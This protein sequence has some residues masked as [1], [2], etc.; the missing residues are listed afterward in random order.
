MQR[1]FFLSSF[2]LKPVHHR[3]QNATAHLFAYF[4]ALMIVGSF[5]MQL[6]FL[7]TSGHAVPYLDGLFTTVS[8]MC[9]TGLST[10][11]MSVYTDT[12]FITILLIIEAG[13]LGLVTLFTVYL[14]F[15]AKHISLE[16]RSLI[17]NYFTSDITVKPRDI[18]FRIIAVTFIIQTIGAIVLA[19]FLKQAGENRFIFYGIFLSISAFCNAGFTPYSDSLQRFTANPA[20]Y[21]TISALIITGGLGFTVISDCASHIHRRLHHQKSGPL[22]LHTEIVLVM[23]ALLIVL[24]TALIFFFDRTNAFNNMTFAQTLGNAFFQSVTVRTAGFDTVAQSSFSAE[25]TLASILLMLVGGSPGSLAGGLKTTTL[26]LL[27]C[28]TF[29]S[30][31]DRNHISVF[32]RD[33]SW[34]S[35]EK[36]VGI[37][38]KGFSIFVIVLFLLLAAEG[39]AL[40]AGAFSV[41][42]IV[43]EI[44]SAFGTVGLSKGVTPLLSAAGK[45][46]IIATMFAGRTGV[47]ALAMQ[48]PTI[49]RKQNEVSEYPQEDILVG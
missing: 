28:Y 47:F 19:L 5:V 46:I 33:I 2:V 6:P 37:M 13:G 20:I 35:L 4:F 21:L 7:Y 9:V 25:S 36:A 39:H 15:P 22:T 12:G 38:M 44:A 23:T 49:H 1:R 17:C 24:G 16:N 43:F 42:D 14:A 10:V 18:L 29:R 8:A 40:A 48:M 3:L 41:G 26:F 27:W 32:R 30:K 34:P 31:K 11:D 45:I